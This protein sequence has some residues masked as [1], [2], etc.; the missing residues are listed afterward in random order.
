MH[1]L[2]RNIAEHYLLHDQSHSAVQ[3][4]DKQA[5]IYLRNRVL[6]AITQGEI[7]LEKGGNLFVRLSANYF[8]VHGTHISSHSAES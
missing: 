5:H 1:F 8:K 4:Q 2:L 3:I 6:D 7:G